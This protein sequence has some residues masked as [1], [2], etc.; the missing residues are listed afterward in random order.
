MEGVSRYRTPLTAEEERPLVASTIPKNTGYNT[1]WA[2]KVFE[3]WQS[4]REDKT[5]RNVPSSSVNLHICQVEDLTTPLHC[6]NAETLNLWLSRFVEEVCNTKGGKISRTNV[7]CYN[8]WFEAIFERQ[9]WI[10]S[11]V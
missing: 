11:T 8:L 7:V 10:G 1:K 9:K 3:Q 4:C 2:V 6:M 5:V